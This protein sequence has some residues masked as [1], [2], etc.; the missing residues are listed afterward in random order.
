[1]LKELG[2]LICLVFLALGVAGQSRRTTSP[3]GEKANR[4]TSPAEVKP[5]PT[6]DALDRSA[7]AGQIAEETSG[8]V[9]KVD[10]D[11]V[12]IPVRILDRNNRFVG[13]LKQ[14][15]FK[16]LEDN[17]EQDIAYFSNEREPFTVALVLDM[18]YSTKFKIGEVQAAAI[19]FIDQLRSQDKVMV[20]SFD[21]DVHVL[22]EPTSDRKTIYAAIKS[23]EISTGTSLYEAM[24]EV[25]NKRLRWIKGRK[26]VILFTDGV[27]TTSRSAD[28]VKNISDALELDALI[29]PIRYD[30]FAD[31]Q[32]MKNKPV[33]T[34][35]TT[36]PI[37]DRKPPPGGL[38][39]PFPTIARPDE[40]GTSPEDYKRAEE[41]LDIL[42]NRTG[43]RVYLASSLVN[44]ADAYS[45][46]ASELREYYSLGYYPKTEGSVGKRRRITVKVDRPGTV[47]RA[48]D[49]Y[50][51]GMKAAKS[52]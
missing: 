49:G 47:V 7:A 6:P 39:F 12:T 1:M 21:Q 31:V 28:R 33:V 29:Y 22:C 3:L 15:D 5:T 25:M 38:P 46:I 17:A 43:G 13:G 11:L 14:A 50:I 10:T 37:P 27:D 2:L 23:T 44:L 20:V 9:I 41:Y 26:A 16:V 24:D 8:D 18:S 36:I 45:K 52:K 51:V 4:R 48:R 30:T 35:T 42:A 19:A 32:A 40:Q 34:Q